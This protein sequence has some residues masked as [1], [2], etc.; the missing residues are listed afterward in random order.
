MYKGRQ[1]YVSYFNELDTYAEMKGLDTQAIIDGIV[2]G[3]GIFQERLEK[4][5]K[6][7]GQ[8]SEEKEEAGKEE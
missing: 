5:E 1:E 3:I 4:L 8:K 7:E 6:A 2:K